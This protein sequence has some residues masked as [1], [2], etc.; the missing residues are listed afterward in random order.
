MAALS[1]A[2]RDPNLRAAYQAMRNAGKPAKLALVAVA[3][4]LVIIANALAET[5]Q[6]YSPTHHNPH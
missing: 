3:R 6:P 4:R 5:G 2:R 1:A